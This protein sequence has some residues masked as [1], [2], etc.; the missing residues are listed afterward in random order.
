VRLLVRPSN[1]AARALYKHLDYVEHE[2]VLCEFRS[3]TK[4]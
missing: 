3:A 2:A 4:P 1:A